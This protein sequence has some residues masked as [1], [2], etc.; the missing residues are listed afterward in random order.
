MALSVVCALSVTG[1][2][3][4]PL[5]IALV[6]LYGTGQAVFQPSFNAIVPMIVPGDMLV[7]ANSLG[8]FVRP[9]AMSMLGPLLGA[10]S[11]GPSGPGGRSAWTR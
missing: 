9:V 1:T 8:Q 4:I 10:C 11:S 6:A 3:T 5:L 7:E 2:L